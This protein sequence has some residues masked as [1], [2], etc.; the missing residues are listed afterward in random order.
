MVSDRQK[1]KDKYTTTID[2]KIYGVKV[3]DDLIYVGKTHVGDKDG[4]LRRTKLQVFHVNKK[5]QKILKNKKEKLSLI[6]IKDTN[7]KNWY[8]DRNNE[9]H[10]RY[11]GGELKLVNDPWILNGKKSYWHGKVKDKHTIERMSESKHKKIVQ[12]DNNGVYIKTWNSG[13][14]IGIKVF[15]DYKVNN[16]SSKSKIYSII[17]TKII[18]NRLYLNSYWFTEEEI[19]KYFSIIPKKLNIDALIQMNKESKKQ[20][21]A[22]TSYTQIYKINKF[23]LK[24][25]LIRSYD[26]AEDAAQRCNVNVSTIRKACRTGKE[27]ELC[28]YLWDYGEKQKMFFDNKKKKFIK[29]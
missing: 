15:K 27:K 9:A 5:L 20:P 13:K 21:H 17:K 14:E 12:F 1:N 22:Q 16:G 23:T 3:D 6:E 2:P 4:N 24:G 10:L 29:K 18:K 25:K 26:T 19:L 28:G 8:N 7:L 11:V